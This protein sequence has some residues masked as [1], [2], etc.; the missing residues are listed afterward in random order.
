MIKMDNS[1]QIFMNKKSFY[2][3]VIIYKSLIKQFK[4]YPYNAMYFNIYG[5]ANK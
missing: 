4:I 2:N 1:V 3:T 5:S